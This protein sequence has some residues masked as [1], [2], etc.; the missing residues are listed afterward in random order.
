MN[1]QKVYNFAAIIS[2]VLANILSI[3]NQM[4]YG[5]RI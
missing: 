1:W 3:Q 4:L 2:L 5:A